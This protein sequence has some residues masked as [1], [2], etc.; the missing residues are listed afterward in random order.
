M[1]S[2]QED[3]NAMSLEDSGQLLALLSLLQPKPEADDVLPLDH[4][5]WLLKRHWWKILATVVFCTALTAILCFYVTPVYEATASIAI[6]HQLPSTAIGQDSAPTETGNLDDL[7][8]TEVRII[9]SDPVLRPV[10]EQYHLLGQ[11]KTDSLSGGNQS[12]SLPGQKQPDPPLG[13]K[14]PDAALGQKQTDSGNPV[15]AADGPVEL[16]GLTVARIPSSL[17]INIVYRSADRNKAA[18]IANAIANSY[19][20]RGMEMRARASMGSSAFMEKQIG[21]LKKNMD[22]SAKA[23]AGY[24]RD[25]GLINP[26]EKTS[27]LTARILQLNTQYTDAQNDRVRKETDYQALKSGDS[28]ALEV[29]PEAGPLAKLDE[30]LHVAQEKMAVVK[31]VYGPNYAEYKRAAND[32]GE[33]E[34][35]YQQMRTEVARRIQ[36]DYQEAKKRESMLQQSLAEAKSESDQ[37]N[38]TSL[39]NQQLKQEAE[40]NKTLYNE[41]FRKI[42]EAGINAGFQSG[43]IRIADEARPQL[44]PVFPKK[45]LFIFLGFL[46]SLLAS[47]ACVILS[48]ILNKTLRDPDQARRSIGAEVVGTLPSVRRFPVHSRMLPGIKSHR[49]A[50]AR[51]NWAQTPEFYEECIH[52]L[53]SSLLL[54]RSARKLKSI[55]ITSAEPGEGKSTC[56]AHMAA[57][58]ASRGKRTLLIDADLRFPS[59]HRLFNIASKESLTSAIAEGR[60][61]WQIRQPVGHTDKLDVIVA[62]SASEHMCAQVAVTVSELLA[63][64]ALE[65]DLI[66]VDAPPML[67]LSEPI[68]MACIA[69]GVL[70]IGRAGRTDQRA[71]AAVFA[72]LRRV[73]ANILGLVINRADQ[74]LSSSYRHRNSARKYAVGI[75][76]L[77]PGLRRG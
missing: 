5:I 73:Q 23:L 61:L 27:I 58:S 25:L 2:Q 75:P 66:I 33:V 28:A 68:Q 35:Q 60:S 32:L 38:A 65:Y 3:R 17:I 46:L 4:Y 69:D 21:E 41:L 57:A 24:E 20:T 74:H 53:L 12:D 31:T 44:H 43:T 59:Q 13:Q 48:D 50:N 45:G 40:A 16:P 36:V 26:D 1:L 7:L 51:I 10:A 54:D 39:K 11:N 34:R 76:G 62:G 6:D 77:Q 18:S 52:T 42:K 15:R 63:E 22:D 55:V 8:N 37:L 9:Q 19:I 71:V 30:Q 49:R 64:A 67:F 14:Q 72:A 47:I 70:V 29:S 56:A